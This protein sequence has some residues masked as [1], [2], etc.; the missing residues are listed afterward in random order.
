VPVGYTLVDIKLMKN[1]QLIKSAMVAGI[2][3]M[4]VSSS[5]D[6]E[7]SPSGTDDVV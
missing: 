2:M 7:L 3:G 6:V 5:G 4:Q 1:R